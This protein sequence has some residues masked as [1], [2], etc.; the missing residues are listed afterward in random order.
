MEDEGAGPRLL[1]RPPPH[2]QQHQRPPL[3]RLQP[4]PQAQTAADWEKQYASNLD[5]ASLKKGLKVF[6]F[7]TGKDD[8]LI[9][10]T[11]ATVELFK[12]HGFNPIMKESAGG[13]TWI[14]WRDYLNEFAPMLFQ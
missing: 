2:R 3:P 6:W 12:K 14:N 1:R 4:R 9:T 7:A 13:H 8:G 11:N 5:N 10:T